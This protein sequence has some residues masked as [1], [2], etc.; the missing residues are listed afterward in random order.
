MR[1]GDLFVLCSDGLHDPV[2]DDEI[3]D[4]VLRLD[5]K[6]ACAELVVNTNGRLVY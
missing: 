4:A 1:P 2:D 6:A 5:P 3:K